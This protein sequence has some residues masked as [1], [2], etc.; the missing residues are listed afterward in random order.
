MTFYRKYYVFHIIPNLFCVQVRLGYVIL[1]RVKTCLLFS[2]VENSFTFF[3]IDIILLLLMPF[4]SCILFIY[5][6]NTLLRQI[7]KKF[8]HDCQN[9]KLYDPK[10]PR[11]KLEKK[12]KIKEI[13]I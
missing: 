4:I 5:K 8:T 9:D 10:R 3:L 2:K 12:H 7:I 1:E 13:L 11:V 6:L